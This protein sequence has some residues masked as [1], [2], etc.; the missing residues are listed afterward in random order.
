MIARLLLLTSLVAGCGP[1]APY[2]YELTY[3]PNAA[4]TLEEA[5]ITGAFK[6]SDP[7]R[8]VSQGI[9]E[10]ISPSNQLILRSPPTPLM[11][12]GSATI[13][14]VNFTIT[15]TPEVEGLHIIQLWIRDLY[16]RPSNKLQGLVRASLKAP[17]P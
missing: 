16:E 6:Y 17:P 11:G 12:T 15:F 14:T 8:D 9:Y 4:F 13:G 7:D 3:S 10:V 5:T 1:E 2:I